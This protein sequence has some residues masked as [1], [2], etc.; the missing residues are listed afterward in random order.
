M[1][2][3]C[4][5][6]TTNPESQHSSSE[7]GT[8]C[9]DLEQEYAFAK[10]VLSS[11]VE[12]IDQFYLL[13]GL[14]KYPSAFL[15]M[16]SEYSTSRERLQNDL[17]YSAKGWL[18]SRNRPMLLTYG[19]LA[20]SYLLIL[21]LFIIVLSKNATS[22]ESQAESSKELS[23]FKNNVAELTSK[24]AKLEAATKKETCEANW[25][26]FEGSCYYISQTKSNW[27]KARSVCERKQSYLA[28][29]TSENEQKFLTEKTATGIGSRY[30]IGLNDMEEEGVWTWVD[31]TN[32]TTSYK[33]WKKGEPNNDKR[34]EDCAHMW[35]RGEWNDVHCTYDQCYA[36]CEKKLAS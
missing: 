34:N 36:I 9:E 11:S 32:Y 14:L 15:T 28:V 29:I 3:D 19:L 6:F 16:D 25:L 22:G 2:L 10:M 30:W 27:M 21:T 35:T 18:Y 13:L 26:E 8:A 33:F 24:M 5:Y 4:A 31:G 20:L 7:A 17:M 1:E 12:L 23:D